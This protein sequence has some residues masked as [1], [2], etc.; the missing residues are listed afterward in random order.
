[1][2]PSFDLHIPVVHV[3]VSGHKFPHINK[4]NKSKTLL[5]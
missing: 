5:K 4:I 1:M 3:H 2:T